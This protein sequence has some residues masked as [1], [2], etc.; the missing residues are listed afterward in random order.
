MVQLEEVFILENNY[1][2]KENDNLNIIIEQSYGLNS[3]SISL[4]TSND[5]IYISSLLNILEDRNQLLMLLLTNNPIDTNSYG[6]IKS[7]QYQFNFAYKNN[8]FNAIRFNYWR[9][10]NNREV[11]QNMTIIN[12]DA[13]QFDEI[14]RASLTFIELFKIF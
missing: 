1:E 5:K 2:F 6:K 13:K 10:Y 4:N 8:S 11:A 14:D 9:T 12:S 3:N 7:E